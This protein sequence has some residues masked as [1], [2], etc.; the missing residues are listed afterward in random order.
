[1]NNEIIPIHEENGNFPVDGRELH[2]RLKIETPYHKWFPRMRE[3]GFEEGKD[4]N[5][6]KIEQVQI[7]GKREVMRE[8]VN[9]HLTISMAKEICMLQRTDQGR[10]VRKYLISKENHHE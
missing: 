7:E 9:H 6:L 5:S 10:T 3:Y 1:M 8:V 4:F 2:E